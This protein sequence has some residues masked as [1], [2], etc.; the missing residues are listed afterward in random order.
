MYCTNCGTEVK[1][2]FCSNCGQKVTTNTAV[3]D[4]VKIETPTYDATVRNEERPAD[5]ARNMQEKP[6]GIFHYIKLI[7]M[8]YLCAS[9]MVSGVSL[10]TTEV[11]AIAGIIWFVAG[12]VLCPLTMKEKP[13]SSKVVLAFTLFFVGM[14]FMP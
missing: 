8:W 5:I 6:K 9:F 12:I 7:I 13:T 1:G 4:V 3:E 14:F 2:N 11:S 10:V